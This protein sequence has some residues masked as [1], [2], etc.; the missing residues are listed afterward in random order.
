MLLQDAVSE[1]LASEV[2]HGSDKP[3]SS[4]GGQLPMAAVL[5]LLLLHVWHWDHC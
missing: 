2:G 4:W 5:L 3:T 1:R